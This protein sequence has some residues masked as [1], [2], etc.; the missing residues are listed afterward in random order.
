MPFTVAVGAQCFTVSRPSIEGIGGEGKTCGS[1]ADCNS[2][3]S[4]QGGRQRLALERTR[5]ELHRTPLI[6]HSTFVAMA[7]ETDSIQGDSCWKPLMQTETNPP[8]LSRRYAHVNLIVS[9]RGS[10]VWTPTQSACLRVHVLPA[11]GAT[12]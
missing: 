8:A 9:G 4:H 2:S 7:T 6:P 10:Q 5:F 11:A 1:S 3:F 12:I